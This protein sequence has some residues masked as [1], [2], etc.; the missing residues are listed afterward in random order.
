MRLT[1]VFL[2]CISV[3]PGNAADRALTPKDVA[4]P[5]G[6]VLLLEE[7]PLHPQAVRDHSA[8]WRDLR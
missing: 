3:F 8:V 1:I 4:R 5:G 6:S 7:P 2:L